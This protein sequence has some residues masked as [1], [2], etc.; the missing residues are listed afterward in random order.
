MSN[1]VNYW[2]LT[3]LAAKENG[4]ISI[5]VVLMRVDDNMIMT[6]YDPDICSKYFL[7][8]DSEDARPFSVN[9]RQ[10]NQQT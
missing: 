3:R 8:Y 10:N 9:S 1:D 4:V 6:S 7:I 5:V 2:Q